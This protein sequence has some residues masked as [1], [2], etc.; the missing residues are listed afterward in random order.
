MEQNDSC[1]CQPNNPTVD[2]KT[3]NS[4]LITFVGTPI[5]LIYSTCKIY[6]QLEKY[7]R[8]SKNQNYF[9]RISL[10]Y[11]AAIGTIADT[12]VNTLPVSHRHQL[13]HMRVVAEVVLVFGRFTKGAVVMTTF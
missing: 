11:M 9:W 6:D 2:L 7:S 1:L 5:N 8:D 12:N 10:T 13:P 4:F 3:L